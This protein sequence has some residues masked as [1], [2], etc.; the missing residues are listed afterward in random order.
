[1]SHND[2]RAEEPE[3]ERGLCILTFIRHILQELKDHILTACL[4]AAAAA[5]RSL[6]FPFPPVILAFI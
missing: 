5:T 1:M 3:P 2:T 6:G 4:F